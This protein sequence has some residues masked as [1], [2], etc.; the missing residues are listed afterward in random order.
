MFAGRERVPQM[1]IV[2]PELKRAVPGLRPPYLLL[3]RH[4]RS[5][6]KPGSLYQAQP[7]WLTIHASRDSLTAIATLV[8]DTM[9]PADW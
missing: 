3:G 7:K 6:A 1:L 5:K 4:N 2:P 9:H 8:E